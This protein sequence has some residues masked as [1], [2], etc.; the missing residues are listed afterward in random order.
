MR[1]PVS[2]VCEQPR[3]LISAIVIRFLDSIMPLVS[4]SKIES[5]L[6]KIPEDKFSRDVAH[7]I[8]IVIT[9]EN[10]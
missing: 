3:S 8:L 1:N 9:D 2:A 6:V 5:Y 7:L 10:K 4:I